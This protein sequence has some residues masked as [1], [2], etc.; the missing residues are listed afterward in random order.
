MQ[1][2]NITWDFFVVI[3]NYDNQLTLYKIMST[4]SFCVELTQFD[5]ILN[6]LF[7]FGKCETEKE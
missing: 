6:S 1:S 2:E 3:L 4:N 5:T 7:V